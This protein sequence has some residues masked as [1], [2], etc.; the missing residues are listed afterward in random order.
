VKAL[1]TATNG[2]IFAVEFIKSDG[3]RRLLYGRIGAYSDVP[4]R[5]V[6]TVWDVEHGGYRSIPLDRVLSFAIATESKAI[7][8]YQIPAQ[9]VISA[10]P[11]AGF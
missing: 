4:R 3:S 9:S 1:I 11:F 6:V 8:A 2:A 7:P 5:G 10:D